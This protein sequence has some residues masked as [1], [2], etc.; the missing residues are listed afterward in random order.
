MPKSK[1]SAFFSVLL[2]FLSG[3]AMGAVAYRLYAVKTVSSTN[4]APPPKKSPEETRKLIINSLKDKVHLDDSQLAE[5]QKIYQ[6]QHE[7]FD[8][9][10]AKYQARL[11][12]IIDPLY[13]AA[14][15]ERDQIHD[16]SIAKIKALLRPDQ[17]PLY[18][19]WQADRAAAAQKRRQDQV[20]QDRDHPDAKRRSPLQRPPLP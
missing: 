4:P 1:A 16:R 3:A 19:K 5:V 6:E 8:A 14:N 20:Q 7:A 13:K 9:V 15:A 2:V 17:V 10:H 18:D 12:P 11:D